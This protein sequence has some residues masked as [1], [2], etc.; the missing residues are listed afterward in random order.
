MSLELDDETYELLG[1]NSERVMQAAAEALPRRREQLRA[2]WLRYSRSQK[3][4][5]AVARR[6]AKR[7]ENGY[8]AAHYAANKEKIKARVKKWRES[9]TGEK[10]AAYKLKRKIAN[11]ERYRRK[12]R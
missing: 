12:K 4:K 2:A 6:E 5:E 8:F 1:Y 10:L 9:L 7:R 11:A 3:G